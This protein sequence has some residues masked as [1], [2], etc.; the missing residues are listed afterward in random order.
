MDKDVA[1]RKRTQIAKASRTMFIWVACA[2]VIVGFAL[3]AIVFLIQIIMFNER[4][5]QQKEATSATLKANNASVPELE[6]QV[7]ALDANAN[8]ATLAKQSS[9]QAALQIILDALPSNANSLA[10][11]ASL[12]NVLLSGVSNL[13]IQSILVEPVVGIETLDASG[14]TTP[15]ADS[16]SAQEILFSLSVTGDAVALKQVLSNLENS[17]RTI[18][19]T[20]FKMESQ[21]GNGSLS[22]D[23]QA[24]AFYVP[25][26][27]VQL[28]D[29]TV[30]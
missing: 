13:S 20:S 14:S 7:R 6:K 28:K 19:V 25:V 30:K 15:T 12:Q 23:I 22:M 9:D 17:L 1:I 5:L 18:D 3:V 27:T 11:G 4:V 16:S 2:S 26:R 10:L 29:M 8:L 21:S 24:K